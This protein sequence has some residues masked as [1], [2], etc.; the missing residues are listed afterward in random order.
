MEASPGKENGT[1]K[2]VREYFGINVIA[3]L[4][5]LDY[6][7]SEYLTFSDGKR[8]M[9]FSKYVFLEDVVADASIF[10]LK[11]D[12]SGYSFVSEKFKQI[13]EE[14]KLSGFKLELVWDSEQE[15]LAGN[16]IY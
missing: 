9:A 13:V 11:D 4:D 8:I 2:R 14:N 12:R 10:K 7:K 15:S 16:Y 5:A 1:G 3:V 6:G